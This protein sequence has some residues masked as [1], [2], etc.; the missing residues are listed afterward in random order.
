MPLYDIETYIPSPLRHTGTTSYRPNKPTRHTI[1]HTPMLRK[2][3]SSQI[4]FRGGKLRRYNRV[5]I[6]TR[7]GSNRTNE[8]YVEHCK[9][10]VAEWEQIVGKNAERGL[11]TVWVMGALTTA[12][13]AGIA[14]PKTGEEEEWLVANRTTFEKLAEEGDEDFIELLAEL[15]G[16]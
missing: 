3:V 14:R 10:V 15:D 1:Q 6:R 9:A 12:L 8:I 11:R 4:V 13:E 2:H 5:I 16:E 7:A